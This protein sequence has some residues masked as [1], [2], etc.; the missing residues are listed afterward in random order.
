M[1]SWCS[2][3]LKKVISSEKEKLFM[4]MQIYR[5]PIDRHTDEQKFKCL[6]VGLHQKQIYSIEVYTDNYLP[7]P[8]FSM[9]WLLGRVNISD[10]IG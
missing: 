6:C 2:S 9:T 7:P 3:T 1:I 10:A 4:S 8:P 5:K